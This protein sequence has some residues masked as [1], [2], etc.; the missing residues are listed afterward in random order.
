MADVYIKHGPPRGDDRSGSSRG[1]KSARQGSRWPTTAHG[2]TLKGE[3]APQTLDGKGEGYAA[4]SRP[5]PG[6]CAIRPNHVHRRGGAPGRGACTCE[7]LCLVS[8]YRHQASG[9]S[10]CLRRAVSSFCWN[11]GLQNAKTGPA[12]EGPEICTLRDKWW[13][14]Q[15]FIIQ[16]LLIPIAESVMP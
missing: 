3:K 9:C 14:S 10:R 13:L 16:Q 11:L 8:K 1:D 4:H 12:S 15:L 5:G 6:R 7:L 2:P